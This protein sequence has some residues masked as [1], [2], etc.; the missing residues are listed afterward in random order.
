MFSRISR[1]F[2]GRGRGSK[3]RAKERLQLVLVHDRA[4]ISPRLLDD[5]KADIIQ[6]ISQ[7]VDIDPASTEM[8]LSRRGEEV[9][10]VA[11]I[12]IRGLRRHR[13]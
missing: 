9:T 8:E 1:I 7:H 2:G 4:T 13:A 11:N 12:P 6:V 10:L 3:S 5:M